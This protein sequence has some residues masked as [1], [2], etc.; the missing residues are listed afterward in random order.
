MSD[1]LIEAETAPVPVTKAGKPSVATILG[2]LLLLAAIGAGLYV[3][4]FWQ[5][6]NSRIARLKAKNGDFVQLER[7]GEYDEFESPSR[8]QE[9]EKE[10]EAGTDTSKQT[11]KEPAWYESYVE[12]MFPKPVQIIYWRDPSLGPDDVNLLLQFADLE[13]LSISCE[14]IDASTIDK[15]LAIPTLR[16]L[17]IKATNIDVSKIGEWKVD[18]KLTSVTLTNTSWK[19]DDMRKVREQAKPNESLKG[20][21][22]VSNSDR[23]SFGA[24]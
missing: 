13:V 11:P 21:L 7:R 6:H 10:E 1:E 9:G 17:S 16:R 19:N 4:S 24:G 18:K 14:S 15:F 22:N 20:K 2:I 23:P 3:G 5:S 12:E 8:G